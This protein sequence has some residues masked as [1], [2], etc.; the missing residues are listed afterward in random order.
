MHVAGTPGAD[1]ATCRIPLVEIVVSGDLDAWSAPRV[2]EVLEEAL[3]LEPRRIII[4]LAGC[5]SIDAAG[6][7]LLLDAHRRAM[8]NGG[9]VALRSPGARLRRNLRLAHVDRVLQVILPVEPDGDVVP[10][11]RSAG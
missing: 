11:G 6:I 4:D 10:V 3:T 9:S 5:P 1:L 8:H 7:M 2:N